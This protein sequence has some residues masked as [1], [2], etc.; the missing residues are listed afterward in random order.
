MAGKGKGEAP[1]G[2]TTSREEK[3]ELVNFRSV[4]K[5]FV[6]D[7]VEGKKG[8]YSIDTS[9]IPGDDVELVMVP[10][11]LRTVRTTVPDDVIKQRNLEPHLQ[12]CLSMF[13]RKHWSVV[14][15]R[16]RDEFGRGELD[17]KDTAKE[18]DLH[19]EFRP[20]DFAEEETQKL[21][22]LSEMH[23]SEETRDR[24]VYMKNLGEE[25]RDVLSLSWVAG[26]V[27]AC[28][29]RPPA[30]PLAEFA[31]YQFAVEMKALDLSVEDIDVFYGSVALYQIPADKAAPRGRISE[32]F[33]FTLTESSCWGP[34]MDVRPGPIT[35]ESLARQ[36]I[37]NIEAPSPDIIAVFR[38]E[39]ILWGEQ[40]H[41]TDFYTRGSLKPKEYMKLRNE[42]Q[43]CARRLGK[44]TQSFVCA[45]LQVFPDGTGDLDEKPR[46]VTI[47]TLTRLAGGDMCDEVVM[48]EVRNL[49][50]KGS[51][52]DDVKGF[53]T[54]RARR[55]KPVPGSI[56]L[57]L[58]RVPPGA[59]VPNRVTTGLIPIE[60][61]SKSA[62]ARIIR[63]CQR[64]SLQEE[65]SPN[66]WI[67]YVHHL[68]V[69]PD[70]V[71]LTRYQ[72]SCKARNL[73][74]TVQL[75]NDDV[76]ETPPGLPVLHG[77]AAM[78]NFVQSANTNV[79]YHEQ[80]P[81]FFEEFVIQLPPDVIANHHLLFTLHH[82]NCAASKVKKGKKGDD[83]E[84]TAG[85]SW[86]RVLNTQ[87]AI[88]KDG[89]H[90]LPVAMELP[91]RYLSADPVSVKWV[92]KQRE[93]LAIRTRLVSSVF[94]HDNVVADFFRS[95]S[96][97]STL[98]DWGQVSGPVRQFGDCGRSSLVRFLP[99]TLD[100]LFQLIAVAD[101][102]VAADCI[103]SLHKVC[104]KIAEGRAEGTGARDPLLSSYISTVFHNPKG[105]TKGE[106]H[107]RLLSLWQR[108]L[109][110]IPE[111]LPYSWVI[112]EIV[113][114]SRLE[115][116]S[117]AKCL[118]Y[119]KNEKNQNKG[120]EK[121]LQKS[122][123]SFINYAI[124][125][126]FVPMLGSRKASGRRKSTVPQDP[127]SLERIF[128][129]NKDLALFV[130][131]L[132]PL[133]ASSSVAK[134]VMAYAKNM[135]K[136]MY[137]SLLTEAKFNFLRVI[138]SYEHFIALN[139]V[140][141]EFT[142]GDVNT[143]MAQWSR[144]HVLSSLLCAEGLMA[145]RMRLQE[146]EDREKSMVI[147][148]GIQLFFEHI[149]V[150][151]NDGRYQSSEERAKVAYLYLPFVLGLVEDERSN[152][153]LTVSMRSR[154]LPAEDVHRLLLSFV[155]LVRNMQPKFLQDW[156]R[157]EQDTTV[158][159]FFMILSKALDFFAVGRVADAELVASLH[160]LEA[161][162]MYMDHMVL[163]ADTFD[164]V[165]QGL[166][167]SID[168]GTN[169]DDA[170]SLRIPAGGGGNTF[171]GGAGTARQGA[172]TARPAATS[173]SS[174]APPAT[175]GSGVRRF[176][177]I[178]Q[179]G[180]SPSAEVR[181]EGARVQKEAALLHEISVVCATSL[182]FVME[183]FRERLN[184]PRDIIMARVVSNFILLLLKKNQS[185]EF[186]RHMYSL[187]HF[188]VLHFSDP[189]FKQDTPYCGD[190][191][192]ELMRQCNFRSAET[193]GQA[194]ATLY[195]FFKMCWR[196]NKNLIRMKLQSSV[197]LAKLVGDSSV[198]S[199]GLL[200]GGL[201]AI[202]EFSK[203]DSTVD[204]EF[205]RQLQ[206]LLG[207]RLTQILKN[208]QR[209]ATWQ[210]DPEMY[211][212][213]M[214]GISA[215]WLDS[216][217]IRFHWLEALAKQQQENGCL[218]EAAQCHIHTAA[219]II[220]HIEGL[221]PELSIFLRHPKRKPHI[222]SAILRSAPSVENEFKVEVT[223][224]GVAEGMCASNTFSAS[225]LEKVVEKA[226]Q[227]LQKAQLHETAI[228]VQQVM[229]YMLRTQRNWAKLGLS[230][231]DS[232]KWCTQ[233]VDSDR[234]NRR[235]FSNY[236][237]VSFFGNQ[238]GSV[239]G[240]S[241]V[242]KELGE[243]RLSDLTNRLKAQYEK[244]FSSG[245]EIGK[246][247]LLS[248]TWTGDESTLKTDTAYLQIASVVPYLTKEDLKMRPSPWERNSNLSR[249][250]Y[251]SP[252]AIEGKKMSNAGVDEIGKIKTILTTEHPFPFVLKRI[253]VVNCEKIKL[254]PIETSIELM[255]DR[256]QK[257][258]I[259][260]EAEY[261]NAKTLQIVLQGSVLL[262]VNA[263]P[264]EI[265]R[266]FVGGGED[267][268]GA[269][270]VDKLRKLFS[271]FIKS[272]QEA[273]RVNAEVI[274][275][276]QKDFHQELERGFES[277]KTEVRKYLKTR[278]GATIGSSRTRS[279]LKDGSPRTPRRSKKKEKEREK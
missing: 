64:F 170:K 55:L 147:S 204:E 168:A 167:R 251:E 175:P 260:Y 77:R 4:S 50:G 191:T 127:L 173:R 88:V 245:G 32:M 178:Q 74:I 70:F 39:K 33:H 140:P 162:L 276:D 133:V 197:A 54:G 47:S 73:S 6:A 98:K 53:L 120:V 105:D 76:D 121:Q 141:S 52:G 271:D 205:R 123:V 198:R 84:E 69:Y 155:W 106:F 192:F 102:D 225:G 174:L 145:V 119:E 183:E 114:K 111:G 31:G 171:R 201:V 18:A 253:P 153:I 17:V 248:N 8:K 20:G 216:P 1:G 14:R 148:K 158:V 143:V 93:L 182:V 211:A 177:Q 48:A 112:F 122:V 181:G 30:Q 179:G 250:I 207:N 228:D 83:V 71:N 202:V 203:T 43:D 240:K 230:Y 25:Q 75:K 255:E 58:R 263:G 92:D 72:G 29:N 113:V 117:E 68:Y 63:E 136:N 193:R 45:A 37:F 85:Y 165:R 160:A 268:Y 107:V 12:M 135:D 244:Q 27:A 7:E 200:E 185:Q 44:Y 139:N 208:V 199:S 217:D 222:L 38:F 150:L 62:A 116:L 156:L 134:L 40:G 146:G 89:E 19:F 144:R 275:A 213:V 261:P 65:L 10:R 233:I 188:Y 176:R 252:Y 154:K 187:L 195:L 34:E 259:E 94:P 161:R 256:I 13:Q 51:M 91:Q 210:H 274:K 224:T 243:F 196:V 87:N 212:D 97:A 21:T 149:L 273:L 42:G 101:D 108:Y 220:A 206:D 151:S 15:L 186:L 81:R 11:K 241:L 209:L 247:E 82:V 269:E 66:P 96:K 129:F 189:I 67:T 79:Q 190:L 242:Y 249:F 137:G 104:L 109:K 22:K 142:V 236:Y 257:L 23:A 169:V 226:L 16:Y 231:D 180:P 41:A 227:N 265:L 61:F 278:K 246:V 90:E 221:K 267:K 5:M 194:A 132:I 157:R 126:V 80:R 28:D 166:L 100:M 184:K 262:Q 59:K 163:F 138:S 235:L 264:L 124:A 270:G 86:M 130:K 172:P 56:K 99:M 234:T 118:P 152:H 279:E 60:P 229:V 78:A 258:K 35:P 110:A 159:Y 103:A 3:V 215:G 237:R 128:V 214:Y 24:K 239:N 232:A 95:F 36:A 164:P 125:R 219:L 272:C 2:S 218:E 115:V 26:S 277:V 46:E 266:V 57:E 238:F 131:D 9:G 254:S 49:L 223:A